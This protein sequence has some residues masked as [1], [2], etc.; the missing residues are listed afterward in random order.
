MHSLLLRA[1]L[2]GTLLK[3]WAASFDIAVVRLAQQLGRRAAGPGPS[4]AERLQ[5]LRETAEAYGP[6]SPERF[7]AAPPS[8][9][10]VDEER[11]RRLPRGGEV[12]DL[13]WQSG[14]Q[15]HEPRGRDSYLAFAEN[16]V[17]HARLLRHK[18][19]RPAIICLHGYRAGVHRFEELAWRAGRLH[20]LGL[21]VALLTLPFHARRSQRG[22]PASFPSQRAGRTIE[23]FGQA[24]WD[25]R[26]LANWLRARGAPKVGVAGMSLGGYTAALAATVE[27]RL[28]FAV[29]YIPLADLTEVTVEHEALRGVTVPDSLTDAGRR[30]L[31]LVQP[32][33][34]KPVIPGDRMLVVAAEVDRITA[35]RT[36]AERLAAH[37]GA[38]LVKFPGSH[39]I[40]LGRAEGFAAMEQLFRR[41]GAVG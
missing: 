19:P 9:T 3:G 20:A 41:A 18:E 37:F 11:V 23:G 24:I 21:D 22:K 39:L 30:A 31:Q 35:A 25:L 27:P 4:H 16:R 8:L 26:S 14:W 10:R 17:A 36:H 40:Q 1:P 38:P 5:R 29:L 28:D 15:P 6:I 12:V 33:S 2:V 34:R 32:L 13:S 7:F